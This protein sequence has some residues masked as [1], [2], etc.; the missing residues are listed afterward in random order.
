MN[1]WGID[2]GYHDIKGQWHGADPETHAAILAAMGTGG[3]TFPPDPPVRVIRQ[4][5]PLPFTAE[6]TA[7]DGRTAVVARGSTALPLGYHTARVLGANGKAERELRLIIAPS[8]CHYREG[9]RAW[10]IAAQ[11]YSLRSTGS[12]GIGDLA[13]LRTLAQWTKQ[14]GGDYLLLSPLGANAPCLP[15]EPSPYYASSRLFKNLLYL[16]IEAIPGASELEGLQ[17]AMAFARGDSEASR[18]IDR[19]RVFTSKRNAL[20]RLFEAFAGDPEFDAYRQGA[21]AT[22]E[23]YAI[24]CALADRHG[25]SWYDWPA[26]FR[27]PD[28]PAVREFAASERSAVA[29]HAW[30]QWRIDQQLAASGRMLMHDLPVGFNSGGADGWFF[31]DVLAKGMSVGAP[32]D[33]LAPGG[34]D[35]GLPPFVPYKLQAAGYEPFIQTIRQSLRHAWGLRIDHVMGLFRLFWCPQGRGARYG[36]YVRYPAEDLLGILALESQRAGAIVV[37]EDLGTVEAGVRETLARNRV[38]SYK[39]AVFED[40]RPE[41]YPELAMAALTTH[42]LATIAGVWTGQ[43]EAD[44]RAHG[45][46]PYSAGAEEMRTKL[47]RVSGQE[48]GSDTDEVIL[49]LHQALARAPSALLCA[50]YEDLTGSTDRPNLPGTTRER[51]NWSIL[52]KTPVDALD[53]SPLASA[54]AARL[55]RS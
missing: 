40:Q 20:E 10:G 52:Q 23:R 44:Q 38:L 16:R 32:P 42:D 39:L 53:E 43:D 30:V 7:E 33:E 24:G 31:Q 1:Y 29:F 46:E 3:E 51:P 50:T 49:A 6:V 2:D 18:L 14:H 54:V 4:G 9:L 25:Q 27:H 36:A 13:D 35:W 47:S 17:D 45:L 11:V 21:G 48:P 41:R 37:G 12:W 5:I 55:Q 28:A 22:L 8:A 19:D 34:Q 26:E 15:Q